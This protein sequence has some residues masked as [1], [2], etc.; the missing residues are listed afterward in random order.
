MIKIDN[1]VPTLCIPRVYSNTTKDMIFNVFNNVNIGKIKTINFYYNRN[2]KRVVITFDHW[3]K[4]NASVYFKEKIK[5][6]E[7]IYIPYSQGIWKCRQFNNL[8]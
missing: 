5:R 2:N 4:N 3:F 1:F 6:N 7:W 8:I